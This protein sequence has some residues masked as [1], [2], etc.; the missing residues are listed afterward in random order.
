[1]LPLELT[2]PTEA[3]GFALDLLQICC[4]SSLGQSLLDTW[5][6]AP[7]FSSHLLCQGLLD[8]TWISAL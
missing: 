1:M 6:L 8:Q 5:E 4:W 7:S 2:I 3:L